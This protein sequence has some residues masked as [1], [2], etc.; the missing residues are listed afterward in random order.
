MSPLRLKLFRDLDQLKGQVLTIGLVVACGIASFVAI[1]GTYRS[2]VSTRAH[3]YERY[4]FP[5][6]F[7][8]MERAP[9]SLRDRAQALPGVALVHARVVKQVSLPIASM[10]EA[11][12]GT[13]IGVPSH[14]EP[15]LGG[16]MLRE[17]RMPLPG[18]DDE[19]VVLEAF[20]QAHGLRT[21]SRLP[22]V[23]GGI[24]RELRVVGVALAP[25][26]V[27][28]I[29][30][31]ELIP[32][33]RR[34]GV[35]WMDA[36]VVA[37]A[38]H[39]QGAFNELLVRL[40]PGA[41]GPRVIEALNRMFESYGCLGA[42]LRDRQLSN[43]VLDNDIQQLKT[44]T[45]IMPTIF[46]AVAAF[47]INVVLSRLV[48]L[49]RAQVAT[50]K[51]VGYGRRAV[52]LHYFELALVVV[53][54]G[55]LVGVA[56]GI[57]LGRKMTSDYT[58]FFHFPELHY[59][60]E[61]RVIT[62]A[63]VCS[64]VAAL[65]GALGSV[66]A[67]M[68]LPPAEAMRPEAPASYRRALSERLRLSWLFGQSARMVLRELERRPLR[69]LLSMLG[70]A[71]AA[72]LLVAGRFGFDSVDW[73]M[74]VQF[75][76]SEREDISVLFRRP[77]GEE[78]IRELAHL[79]GVLR[80][81]GLRVLNV[82][83]RNGYK[84]RES[85]LVGYPDD[86]DM[87]RVL[88]VDGTP[89][90]MREHGAIIN[91]TLA[92]ILGLRVGDM[93]TVEVLE[94]K[95]GEHKVRVAG[96]VD[97]VAGLFGHM[98]ARELAAMLGDEGPI[99]IGLLRVD[100]KQRLALQ[101]AL[102]ERPDVLGVN[103]HEASIEM[104]EKTTAGQMRYTTLLLTLFASVIACGVI[105]N[106]ARVALSTRSRDL[107]SLRV[108]GFRRSEI[109]A[110]LLGELAIQVLLALVPGLFLGH[111]LAAHLMAQNDPELY[112]FPVV[113]S[114]RTYGFAVLVTLGAALVSALLVRRR[115]DHLDLIGVLKSRE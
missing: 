88:E 9:L 72:A 86:A 40:Q 90:P 94:G 82:R 54:A 25:E 110:I 23:L 28:A 75:E 8:P 85:A 93:V 51:A 31:G 43:Q 73:Y 78:A 26:F 63:M 102:R 64:I 111:A 60:P 80:A 65:A 83:Y 36:D 104:F 76:L 44:T 89:V 11:A 50:L 95:R 22:A 34:F 112:R 68:Q 59:V 109:S 47:L 29:A 37:T 5:D 30:P 106:N 97:E 103:R 18:R 24:R 107:A 38:F 7:V 33:P 3:Y 56:L 99:S 62:L 84:S 4:H 41:S 2:I 91:V 81:E 92:N 20:A 10:G 114:A 19:A 96:L 71:L 87:R 115:L 13:V 79:P 70:V 16:L 100:P 74:R 66:Y 61:L 69:A 52:G 101:R 67:V 45:E 98:R 15:P 46:L 39:M 35:L 6:A 57:T 32:D 12:T 55:S 42:Y 77:V 58:T 49:Q 17:G 48:Q 27:F 53:G 21:G 14:G 1:Q 108:L 113:V 105:Y